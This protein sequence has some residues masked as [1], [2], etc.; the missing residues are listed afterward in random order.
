MKRARYE[1]PA[2][3]P[4][5]QLCCV[6]LLRVHHGPA[7]AELAQK[8]FASGGAAL[9]GAALSAVEQHSAAKLL[10]LQCAERRRGDQLW[11]RPEGILA[12]LGFGAWCEAEPDARAREGMVKRATAGQLKVDAMEQ[13]LLTRLLI[14]RYTDSLARA[15]TIQGAITAALTLCVAPLCAADDFEFS[16]SRI[17]E[18]GLRMALSSLQMLNKRP[19]LERI[20]DEGE[21]NETFR[22]TRHALLFDP[23]RRAILNTVDAERGVEASHALD[24]LFR[25]GPATSKEMAGK[26]AQEEPALR[27]TLNPLVAEGLVASLAV[28]ATKG[29]QYARY[30]YSASVEKAAVWMLAKCWKALS[31]ALVRLVSC[32]ESGDV[33]SCPLLHRHCFDV[34]CDILLLRTFLEN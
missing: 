32:Y 14:A 17:R 12:L 26:L 25:L 20:S 8:A 15:P 30:S 9:V 3:T 31:H 13:Q 23:V 22:L 2:P 29:R 7:V 19:W 10:R 5:E 1:Q 4:D 16:S 6:A 27:Q 28:A 21:E 18:P 34:Y 11:L 33:A 24:L